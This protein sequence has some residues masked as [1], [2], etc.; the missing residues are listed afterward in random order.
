MPKRYY[1]N[2][3]SSAV[4]KAIEKYGKGSEEKLFQKLDYDKI[5]NRIK[6][7]V[8]QGKDEDD[9]R[10]DILQNINQY[11]TKSKSRRYP[12]AIAQFLLKERDLSPKGYIRTPFRALR[13]AFGV[14]KEYPLEE[15]SKSYS[16]I[17]RELNKL[18]GGEEAKEASEYLSRSGLFMKVLKQMR[19]DKLVSDSTFHKVDRK[20]E[21][22]AKRKA[23]ELSDII[24]EVAAVILLA[25]ATF[26]LVN[27]IVDNPSVTGY[28]ILGISQATT[29]TLILNLL[30]FIFVLLLV[31]P[32]GD[33]MFPLKAAEV[34]NSRKTIRKK[35]K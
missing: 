10:R 32:S 25:I 28:S 27:S 17:A 20:I 19:G 11:A 30:A 21:K 35:R 29:S 3:V 14:Q 31:Y 9:I 24:E 8:L 22:G 1:K 18:P 2:S 33:I 13:E 15:H 26:S 34:K 16:D 12:I 5:N 6:R 4:D 23:K 7:L